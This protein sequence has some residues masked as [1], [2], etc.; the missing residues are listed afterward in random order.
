MEPSAMSSACALFFL[1]EATRS[2][3]SPLESPRSVSGVILP[4]TALV[5]RAA[6]SSEP[7]WS[8]C[9]DVFV[10]CSPAIFS[11]IE[12][13]FSSRRA[14]VVSA[15]SLAP[16]ASTDSETSLVLCGSSAMMSG[17]WASFGVPDSGRGKCGGAGARNRA[18]VSVGWRSESVLLQRSLAKKKKRKR[19]APDPRR[20]WRCSVVVEVRL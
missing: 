12:V 16:G 15:S 9:V 11:D 19:R 20:E 17:V 13:C 5:P 6:S 18:S 8:S 3:K 10:P 2:L 7:L 1:G 14:A 4:A